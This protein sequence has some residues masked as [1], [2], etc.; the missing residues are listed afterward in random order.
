MITRYILMCVSA[1]IPTFLYDYADCI[2]TLYP[3]RCSKYKRRKSG[4]HS[5]VVK[6]D[7]FKIGVVYHFPCSKK[8][9]SVA[10][11]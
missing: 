10:V 8:F 3:L 9:N 1:T 11:A 5:K 7:H 6:F 4:T 2:C